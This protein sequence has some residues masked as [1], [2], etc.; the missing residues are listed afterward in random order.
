MSDNPFGALAVDVAS[1]TRMPIIL[2]G[3][4]DPLSDADGKEAY[5]E[6]LPWDSEPGRNLDRKRNVEAVRK[7]FR[8]KS[9]AELRKEAE[10]EDPVADQVERLVALCVG[11]HLV[12]PDRQVLAVP[13]SEANARKLFESPATAWLRRQAWSYVTNEANFMKSSSES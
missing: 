7:G 13:F 9:R 1:T 6:F 5:L 4:I 10:G 3:E 12:G 8:Q 11:W 2:P